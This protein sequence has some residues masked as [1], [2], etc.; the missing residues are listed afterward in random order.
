MG[1]LGY[2]TTDVKPI[3]IVPQFPDAVNNFNKPISARGFFPGDSIFYS[4]F[5][6]ASSF[7]V[8]GQLFRS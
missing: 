8:S 7:A 3:G 1:C 5:F 4:C 6:A 2:G